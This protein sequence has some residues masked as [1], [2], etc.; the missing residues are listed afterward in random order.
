MGRRFLVV[1]ACALVCTG[2][3]H[4]AP[5]ATQLTILAGDATPGVLKSAALRNR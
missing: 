2:T 1:A 5:M 4:P 3:A